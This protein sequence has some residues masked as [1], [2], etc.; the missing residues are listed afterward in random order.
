MSLDE[1]LAAL[2]VTD[3]NVRRALLNYRRTVARIRGC[4]HLVPCPGGRCV[5]SE[6]KEQDG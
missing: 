2:E 4:E 3:E 6:D 1:E 5:Q